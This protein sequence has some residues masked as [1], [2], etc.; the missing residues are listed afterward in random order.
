MLLVVSSI[1]SLPDELHRIFLGHMLLRTCAFRVTASFVWYLM[2]TVDKQSVQCATVVQRIQKGKM[3][4]SRYDVLP[5]SSIVIV[6]VFEAFM[7]QG[8]TVI[9]KD[10]YSVNKVFL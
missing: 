6:I 2:F 10:K 3:L 5:T 8:C 9:T 1:S 4:T 7:T